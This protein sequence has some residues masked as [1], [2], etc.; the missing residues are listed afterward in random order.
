M[1]A[2][3]LDDRDHALVVNA[4]VTGNFHNGGR[5]ILGGRGKAR[6]VIRAD[7]VVV[8]GLRH[9]DDAALIAD[10]GHITADL[11]AG[12]HGVVAADVEEVAD[13]VLFKDLK[14]ALIVLVVVGRI[15]DLVA[16]GAEGGGR[17]IEQAL[18]LCGILFV[19]NHEPIFQNADDAVLGTI[20][21]GD[22]L[23]L[24]GGFDHAV[25]TGVDHGRG[26]AGLTDDRCT[27]QGFLRG[28]GITSK[29][30]YDEVCVKDFSPI[31]IIPYE[32]RLCKEFITAV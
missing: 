5:D 27:D 8:D 14:D 16:A 26:T 19:H 13:V 23:I 15:G 4:A 2:H 32:P 22:V 29:S 31:A 6:A 21:L 30:R 20:D 25:G 17:R 12:V 3:A 1:A 18:K 11:G 10:L 9:A 28:H 24:E 7:E